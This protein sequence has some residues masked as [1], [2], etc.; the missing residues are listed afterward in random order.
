MNSRLLAIL[1][2]LILGF[3]LPTKAQ[4]DD[5]YTAVGL[6]FSLPVQ[7]FGVVSSFGVGINARFDQRFYKQ[8]SG[9]FGVG[10]SYFT[11]NDRLDGSRADSLSSP[12]IN[13]I[14]IKAGVKY[15]LSK[16][17]YVIAEAGVA[18]TWTSNDGVDEVKR[19]R[20][21]FAPGFGIYTETPLGRFDIH[22]RVEGFMLGAR[23]DLKAS[24]Y[25]FPSLRIAYCF[26]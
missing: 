17:L 16:A 8:F 6:D 9:T 13:Y 24:T 21:C 2:V 3:T 26:Q 20:F 10:Y 19:L 22:A 14:P 15:N 18:R 11:A 5:V 1:I 25:F 7:D 12:F 23:G 4:T